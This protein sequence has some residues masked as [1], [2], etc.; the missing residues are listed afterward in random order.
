MIGA[1]LATGTGEIRSLSGLA[2]MAK[3]LFVWEASKSS[4]V[5]LA[6]AHLAIS[7]VSTST[8]F[9]FHQSR[10][11]ACLRGSL[12]FSTAGLNLA[13]CHSPRATTH[14]QQNRT[15]LIRCSLA[16]SLLRVLIR[17]VAG[18]TLSWSS[19]VPSRTVPHSK[20]SLLTVLCWLRTAAKCQSRRG[21]I[22]THSSSRILSVPTH[23]VFTFAIAL[24][25][26]LSLL[27]S[28]KKACKISFAISSCHGTTLTAS[29]SRTLQGLRRA[30][31]RTSFSTQ[32]FARLCLI[33]LSQTTLISTSLPALS[34]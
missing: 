20:T 21:T 19:L 10:A 8:I 23:A 16:T 2:T 30:Q 31:A 29:A 1:S 34:I 28:Q 26:V 15:N 24:L 4:S 11:K 22:P 6:A 14:S 25:C 5:Y 13:P 7:I 9:K 27:D 17:L 33:I 18:S 3:K 32:A 12:K